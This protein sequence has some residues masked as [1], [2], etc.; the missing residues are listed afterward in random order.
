MDTVL[1][2][3]L[4]SVIN[5]FSFL[6]TEFHPTRPQ[7]LLDKDPPPPSPPDS[8]SIPDQLQIY[9]QMFNSIEHI[10]KLMQS[11]TVI[12]L[13]LSKLYQR[14]LVAIAIFS[15]DSLLRSSGLISIRKLT[16]LDLKGHKR[17]RRLDYR[18]GREGFHIRLMS[19]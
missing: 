11:V 8:S 13:S 10:N 17:S 6:E 16:S 4:F 1:D 7:N 3:L 18:G 9:F 12:N 14:A 5:T 15:C 2:L 19:K